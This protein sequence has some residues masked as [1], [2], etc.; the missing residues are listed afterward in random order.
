MRTMRIAGSDVFR[1]GYRIGPGA[2]QLNAAITNTIRNM[3]QP[4]T[5]PQV[6]MRLA[7]HKTQAGARHQALSQRLLYSIS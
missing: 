4:A 7:G 5:P 2:N 1:F 3:A 6:E